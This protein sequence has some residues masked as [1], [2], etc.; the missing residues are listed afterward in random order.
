ME[1]LVGV[2]D[3]HCWPVDVVLAAPACHVCSAIANLFMSTVLT[4]SWCSLT[5]HARDEPDC[6]TWSFIRTKVSFWFIV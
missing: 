4:A 1:I 3:H 6:K 2:Q 5:L